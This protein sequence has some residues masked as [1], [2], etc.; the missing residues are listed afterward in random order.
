[1]ALQSEKNLVVYAYLLLA[2]APYFYTPLFKGLN[3]LVS[4]FWE[5]SLCCNAV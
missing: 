3:H 5:Y 2:L 1:M 4:Y